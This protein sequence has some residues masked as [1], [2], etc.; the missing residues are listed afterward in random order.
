MKQWAGFWDKII[1]NNSDK[2]TIKLPVFK[3]TLNL[4]WQLIFTWNTVQYLIGGSCILS[5]KY[6]KQI[7]PE[8]QCNTS[9]VTHAYYQWNILNKWYL[10]YSAVLDRRLMHIISEIFFQHSINCCWWSFFFITFLFFFSANNQ[11]LLIL[12]KLKAYLKQL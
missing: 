2:I 1:C 3:I 8:R 5:V 10:K 12:L 4:N 9:K 7:I 11:L 6:F